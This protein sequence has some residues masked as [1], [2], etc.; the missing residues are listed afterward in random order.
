MKV[1]FALTLAF[2]TI[3]FP[4][5]AQRPGRTQN[6][7]DS[8][9]KAGGDPRGK[10]MMIGTFRSRA[11]VSVPADLDMIQTTGFGKAGSGGARYVKTDA[12]GETPY[13][14][15]SEDGQWWELSEDRPHIN[16]FG[17]V[18]DGK[19]D[20]TAAFQAA[21]DYAAAGTSRRNGQGTSIDFSGGGQYVTGTFVL[22]SGVV[23]TDSRTVG[24]GGFSSASSSGALIMPASSIPADSFMI[25]TDNRANGWGINGLQLAGA[26]SKSKT[27]G[28]KVNGGSDWRITNNTFKGWGIEA[29]VVEN[30]SPFVITYNMVQG[31]NNQEY[32]VGKKQPT[33]AIRVSGAD[34]NIMNN[35]FT[36]SA[37]ARGSNAFAV[38]GEELYLGA[39]YFKGL[40][41]SRLAF[42]IYQ[43]A[44]VGLRN[45]GALN[46]YTAERFDTNAGHGLYFIDGGSDNTFVSPQ[47]I[48]NSLAADGMYDGIYSATNGGR[49]TFLNPQFGSGA[50][51]GD[52]TFS[53]RYYINDTKMDYTHK[54]VNAY[55]APRAT[56]PAVKAFYNLP[57]DA[58]GSARVTI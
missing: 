16:M 37:N 53:M 30:A 18:G 33:G 17:A 48:R 29:I 1:I 26:G 32:L 44:D 5:I 24:K 52:K 7:V 8:A 4:V 41:V 20:N 36:G 39:A 2:S 50:P 25:V 11:A 57:E 54:F 14:F 15:K 12:T 3:A 55:Q 13:R 40:Q 23:F 58:E 46:V 21:S 34:G 51:M 47:I 19:T 43:V 45:P 10:S 6:P 49:N 28:I 22:H 42:N 56:S 38:S 27:G 35:E 31:L 9:K